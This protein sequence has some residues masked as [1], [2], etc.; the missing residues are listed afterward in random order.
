LTETNVAIFHVQ[1]IESIYLSDQTFWSRDFAQEILKEA[2]WP[3]P[4][5]Q[6]L[7]IPFTLGPLAASY[8]AKDT[9]LSRFYNETRFLLPVMP[10]GS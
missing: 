1:T 6:I 4:S 10:E 9:L 7:S 2:Q 8:G 5:S 3:G